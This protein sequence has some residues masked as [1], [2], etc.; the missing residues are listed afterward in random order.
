M[1]EKLGYSIDGIEEYNNP[2]PNWLMWIFYISITFSILY[3]IAYPGFWPG[4]YGWSSVKMYEDE[5]KYT[6]SRYAAFR[7]N[8]EMILSI[9]KD[10]ASGAEG[11]KIFSQ[12][13]FA[14]HGT[15][16]KGDTGIGP[17]L[18]D[19]EWLYDGTHEAIFNI[20]KEGTPN[21]M[22]SWKTQLGA[23]KIAKVAAFVHS[24]GGGQ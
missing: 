11:K 2:I 4:I 17:N 24:L 7:P 8:E 19:A 12:N 1:V 5:I 20:V 13:C 21:G 9:M 18:T 23:V 16:G 6:E 22:P 14:C 10:P 3:W 15:E